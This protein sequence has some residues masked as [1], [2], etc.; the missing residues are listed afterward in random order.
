GE[1][2]AVGVGERGA[3]VGEVAGHVLG[4]GEARRRADRRCC[5][6]RAGGQSVRGDRT[7]VGVPIRQVERP[8]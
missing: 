7:R 6:F 2:R 8:A 1:G 3:G 4:D 5:A